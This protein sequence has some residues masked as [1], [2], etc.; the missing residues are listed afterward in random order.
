MKD[1]YRDASRRD[2]AEIK[3]QEDKMTK[4]KNEREERKQYHRS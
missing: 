1:I 3:R 4:R 2:F